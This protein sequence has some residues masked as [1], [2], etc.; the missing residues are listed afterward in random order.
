MDSLAQIV[1]IEEQC[2]GHGFLLFG[3][4]LQPILDF[5]AIRHEV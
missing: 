1:E 5:F 3:W 4:G 2:F